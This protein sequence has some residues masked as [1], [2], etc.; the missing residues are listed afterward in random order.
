MPRS[1]EEASSKRLLTVACCVLTWMLCAQASSADTIF[2][3][4]FNDGNAG[5]GMPVTWVPGSGTWNAS[6]GDYVATSSLP[7][8]SRVPDHVLG[9]T[10][11]RAQARVVGNVGATIAVRRTRVN[12]GYA[13]VIRADGS[14]AIA[15]V[16]GAVPV[17]LGSAV[18]QFNPVKQ[19][20]ML[21]FD[22]FGN[23][24]SLWAWPVGEPMPNE[25]QVVAFDNTYAEGPVGLISSGFT[26]LPSDSTT[27]RFVHVA[28][29]HIPEPSTF[30]LMR[31][32]VCG[33]LYARRAMHLKSRR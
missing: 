3:D 18:V 32:G 31:L 17:S 24:L 1:N 26:G 22:A 19:D 13:G 2:F 4:D 6:S 29:T 30:V 27:F 8:I 14:M 12:Q 20:V 23:K 25:P 28:K 21:Q 11:V 33:L 7:R 10:S 5:D 15:R 16:D 9:D